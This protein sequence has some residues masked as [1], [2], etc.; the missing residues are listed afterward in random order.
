M[1]RE[2]NNLVLLALQE[3]MRWHSGQKRDDGRDYIV[4]LENVLYLLELIGAPIHVQ[5]AGVLHDILEDTDCSKSHILWLFNDVVLDLVEQVTKDPVTK[6]FQIHSSNAW[7]IKLC[8]IVDNL[9]DM[10]SWSNERKNQYIKKKRL[11]LGLK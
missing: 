7:L 9:T 8:D 6:D 2:R 1:E 10:N 3:S 4:H 5:I 11:F